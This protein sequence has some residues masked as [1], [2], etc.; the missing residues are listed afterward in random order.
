VKR[1]WNP[2]LGF[3]LVGLLATTGAFLAAFNGYPEDRA[4]FLVMGGIGVIASAA[5]FVIA[6]IDGPSWR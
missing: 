5:W 3:A 2:W 1:L 6:W 4:M